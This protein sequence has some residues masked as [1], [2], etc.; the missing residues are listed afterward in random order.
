METHF[1]GLYDGHAGGRCSKHLSQAIPDALVEDAA[2]SSNLPIA[3][4]RTYHT[5][6][7]QFL[8]VAE[9]L[10]LHD[11]STGISAV[12][13]DGKLVVANVGDCRALLMSGGKPIQMSNDQ[14]PTSGEEQK[15]IGEPSVQP[16]RAKLHSLSI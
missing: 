13:R 6:N 9:R 10:R 12:L 7:D 8:K 15:R 3:L 16:R 2:F 4:K 1:F 5:V 11:G 14:K